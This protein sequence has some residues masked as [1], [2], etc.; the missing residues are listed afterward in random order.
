MKRNSIYIDAEETDVEMLQKTVS[1]L[2][3]LVDYVEGQVN[4]I[5]DLLTI[6][7]VSDLDNIAQALDVASEL[8]NDLY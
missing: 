5:K 3:E 8:G 6:T 4:E 2:V 7:R 1:E